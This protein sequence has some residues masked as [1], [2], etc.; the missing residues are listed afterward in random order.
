[1]KSKF[2]KLHEL[3]PPNILKLFNEEAAWGILDPKLIQMIDKIK[4]TFPDGSMTINNYFWGGDREWSGLRTTDSSYYSVRSQHAL[5]KASDAI[6]SHYPIKEVRDYII[7]HPEEFTQ[8]G[9]IELGVSW[10]HI[11]TRN[12]VD[13]KIKLFYP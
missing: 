2:F 9:G 6:F 3:V 4:E 11:D 8:V 5:G 7:E 13:N 10:L 12:R 1:M